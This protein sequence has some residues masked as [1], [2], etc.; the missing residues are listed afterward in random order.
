MSSKADIESPTRVIHLIT[1]SLDDIPVEHSSWSRY[2]SEGFA[3]EFLAEKVLGR[4][5]EETRGLCRHFQRQSMVNNWA[6]NIDLSKHS[7]IQRVRWDSQSRSRTLGS[8]TALPHGLL[9]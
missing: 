3:N 6:S 1:V 9:K 4:T 7:N 5:G 2:I 8:L